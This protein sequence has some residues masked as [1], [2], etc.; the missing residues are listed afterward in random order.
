M[1]GLLYRLALLGTVVSL[2]ACIAM[3]SKQL[4]WRT[5]VTSSANPAVLRCWPSLQI[6]AID[7]V[8]KSLAVGDGLWFQQ[9][10]IKIDPGA[11]SLTV[12]H[13]SS[14][15]GPVAITTSTGE[16]E[17]RFVAEPGGIYQL[18]G[19][20]VKTNGAW[21]ANGYEVSVERSEK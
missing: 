3:P 4:D 1:L 12:R 7:E 21:I 17:V 18:T 8:K 15:G 16:M 14:G 11:H 13:Y 9:C 5:D 10:D 2:S 19:K 6:V 20:S